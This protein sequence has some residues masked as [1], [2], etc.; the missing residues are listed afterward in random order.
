[1]AR[2]AAAKVTKVV[3]LL[4]KCVDVDIDCKAQ[5]KQT[6]PDIKRDAPMRSS[7]LSFSRKGRLRSE[8][9]LNSLG[10]KRKIIDTERAAIGILIQNAH[11]HPMVSAITPPRI[12]PDTVHTPEYIFVS[13]YHIS[14]GV[15]RLTHNDSSCS[16][17]KCS[18]FAR[19]YKSYDSHC[20]CNNT[21]G[22]SSSYC[23]TDDKF[24]CRVCSSR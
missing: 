6:R 7:L 23:T 15:W 13:N 5:L 11:C 3:S 12:G 16:F 20:S 2:S 24:E 8:E 14:F 18:I 10:K 9:E 17:E 4:L 22:T 1:V 19:C 21:C